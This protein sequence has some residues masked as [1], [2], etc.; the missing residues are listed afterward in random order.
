MIFQIAPLILTVS[1]VDKSKLGTHTVSV[2]NTVSY[3]GG[4]WTP[5]YSFDIEILDPCDS[6]E[7]QSQSIATLTT[8]NGVVGTV[9]FEEVKDSQE[10][11]RG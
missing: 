1:T 7:L 8:D 4:S 9:D 10:V 6:T 2:V 11:A 3:D 5:T